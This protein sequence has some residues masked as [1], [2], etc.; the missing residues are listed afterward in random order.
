MAQIVL[1]NPYKRS[2]DIIGFQMEAHVCGLCPGDK[3]ALKVDGAYVALAEA[4][5]DGC[6]QLV[7]PDFD[8]R[9]YFATP[10]AWLFV[11]RYITEEDIEKCGGEVWCMGPFTR[12]MG[13]LYRRTC[14]VRHM[15]TVCVPG[16]CEHPKYECD[17]WAFIPTNNVYI[18]CDEVMY[19][20]WN[21]WWCE[22][23]TLKVR[24]VY[25][26]L[27]VWGADGKLAI[28][29]LPN[30][31]PGYLCI[32]RGGHEYCSPTPVWSGVVTYYVL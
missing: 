10:K 29:R 17:G 26:W 2:T 32:L 6:A 30:F 16:I 27:L 9:T 14:V 31:K 28:A 25:D 3:L 8:H 22:P 21:N 11:Q 1:Y 18:T 13:T 19:Y 5:K 12:A 23:R 20:K 24:N 4:D 15:G 7:L